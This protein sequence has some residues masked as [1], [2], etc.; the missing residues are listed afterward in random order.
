VKTDPLQAY[1]ESRRRPKFNWKNRAF[2]KQIKAI[3]DHARLKAIWTTRRGAKSYCD[4]IYLI[5]EMDEQPRCNV[6]YLG[7]TRLS[8]KGIIW[9]DVLKDIDEKDN[10]DL[11]FHET[12]LTVTHPNGALC[13][14]AGVDVDETERRKLF[15][16]KY[17]LVV[18]DEAALYTINL[19]DLV[20]VTLKPAMTDTMGTIVLSGMSS[21][22][23]QGLFYDITTEKEKGWS[24][25]TWTAHDNPFVAKNW[26]TE[27]DEIAR[28]RPD[29]MK[30][31]MFQQAYL[32]KWVTDEDAKVYK[33]SDRN[34]AKELPVYDTPFNYVLGVDLG[35]NPDP[36]AFVIG[37]YHPADPIL[38]LIHAEKHLNMDV[39]NVADKVRELEKSFTFEVKIVDNANAQAVA[40]LNNRHRLNL[41]AAEKHGKQDF[42][43][44]MN[45]EF[46]QRKIMLTFGADLLAREYMSLVWTTEDGLIKLTPSGQRKE[47]PGI[48]NHCTDA[49]LYLWRHC[50]NYLF[51]KAKETVAW[52]SQERWEPEHIKKLE[53]QVQREQNPNTLDVTGLFDDSLFDFSQ[54]DAI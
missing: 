35:H 36:S 19:R 52:D 5:K 49:A 47:H 21:N 26:Q 15:G 10:L 48:P 1:L 2:D 39:T 30:T 37:A 29:F 6:L 7:L 46:I 43:N 4:G 38:Y 12:E 14:V 40:E 16:R 42:I 27:L 45:T 51:Q 22:I 23:T 20:Y 8:A 50:F 54:D 53:E 32:N 13:Y 34:W 28:D 24:L 18:I 11:K 25:H 44:L 9:K 17:R 41:I 33:F 3:E 31:P